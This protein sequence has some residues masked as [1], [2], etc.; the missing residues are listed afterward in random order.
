MKVRKLRVRKS[1]V[2]TLCRLNNSTCAASK[3]HRQRCAKKK[4]Y[5]GDWKITKRYPPKTRVAVSL[6][7]M[8]ATAMRRTPRHPR[9]HCNSSCRVGKPSA[10]HTTENMHPCSDHAGPDLATWMTVPKHARGHLRNA[11]W[12]NL[13]WVRWRTRIHEQLKHTHEEVL[14]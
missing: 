3:W 1:L 11:S 10:I 8:V 6:R 2:R 4:M 14:Q 7:V 12:Y 13:V 5:R 9:H